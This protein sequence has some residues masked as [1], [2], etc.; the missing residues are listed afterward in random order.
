MTEVG[1]KMKLFV[2]RDYSEGTDVKFERKFLQPLEGRIEESVW[3]NTMDHINSLF[4]EAEAVDCLSYC[5]SCVA[6]LTFYLTTLCFKSKYEKYTDKV[7]KYIEQQ[8]TSTFIP[9]GLMLVD[10]MDRGLRCMEVVVL[11]DVNELDRRR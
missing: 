2:Q 7:A 3:L 8:N 11:E 10:P 6:C 5:E 4:A 9:R 1:V